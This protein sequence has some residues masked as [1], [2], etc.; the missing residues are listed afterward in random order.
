MTRAHETAY[1]AGFTANAE[2]EVAVDAAGLACLW[3]C[4]RQIFQSDGRQCR[5]RQEGGTRLPVTWV[6]QRPRV[7]GRR[8]AQR[9]EQVACVQGSTSKPVH[10]LD[11]VGAER[12]PRI[13]CI[14]GVVRV[15]Q[16]VFIAVQPCFQLL[17]HLILWRSDFCLCL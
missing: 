8:M 5:V 7:G 16:G 14:F 17:V 12:Q 15:V 3:R 6:G 11:C 4:V 1:R 10:S 2:I 13:C 9:I